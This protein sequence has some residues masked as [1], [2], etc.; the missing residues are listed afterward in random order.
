MPDVA[1]VRSVVQQDLLDV[2]RARLVQAVLGLYVLF[3]GIIFAGVSLT[4]GQPVYTAI[5]LT[6]FIGFLFIPLV[7]LL[8]GY[9]AIAGERD[10]GTIRFLLG[11]PLKRS[12]VLVGK[13]VSRLGLV[14]VAVSLAF[15][16]AGV[17]S[18]GMFDQPRL[19]TVVT[20]GGLTLLFAGSYMGIAIAVSAVSESRSRAMTNTIVMYFVFTLLWS[21][22][23]PVTVP[24][25]VAGAADLILG[26]NLSGPVWAVFTTLSPAEAYFQSLQLL[27]GGAFQTDGSV[28]SFI[29]VVVMF[30]WMVVPPAVGY[31]SFVHADID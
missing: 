19:T 28:S 11:Y 20:F 18:M 21:R 6:V 29:V 13:Y 3:V 9:L 16:V 2:R 1:A 15:L 22:I 7:S 23:S 24:E 25:V 12:E 26:V 30:A 14:I 17:I 5:Q 31:V 4:P 27:P 8:A 10:S